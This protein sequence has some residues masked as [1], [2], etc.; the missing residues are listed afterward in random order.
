M[1]FYSTVTGGLLDTAELDAEYWYRNVR[2]MVRFAEAVRRLVAAVTGV[3]GGQST[4]GVD[5]GAAGDAR[6]GYEC[7]RLWVH[8]AGTREERSGCC[9]RWASSMFGAAATGAL[10]PAAR[11]VPLPTYAFERQRYWL[12]AGGAANGDVSSAGLLSA[13]H[14]LLGA[15]IA[16]AEGDN[17]VFTGRLSLSTHAWLG[18]HVVFGAVLL[19]GSAFV[20]LALAAA[21]RVGLDTV[22]ELTLE[23]PLVVPERGALQLQVLVGALDE[24]K[25]RSLSVHARAADNSEGGW[26]RHASG[27]L[28]AAESVTAAELRDW[29]PAGAVA[30]ELDGLYERAAEAGLRYSDAFCG[31]R[32]VYRRGE[33]L[34]A[35]VELPETASLDASRF[36]LHP[37]LLDAALH[38][39]LT[40][41]TPD[42]GIALP[43]IWNGVQLCGRGA[44]AL[45]VRLS[46]GEAQ[47]GGCAAGGR[48]RRACWGGGG[49]A[50]PACGCQPDPGRVGA[51]RCALPGGL[52]D[53]ADLARRLLRN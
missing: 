1:P 22:D 17:F 32:A 16:V 5:H 53:A 44:S 20:E 19:P 2:E 7:A 25:R 33:E 12:D 18:G 10:L 46:G 39:L 23:A 43:F 42:A 45:R 24:N 35:Q 47:G 26:T 40:L 36:G 31:L 48:S 29:P 3:C 15:S 50:Y 38:A 13:E 51:A 49:S 21:Q 14:P 6:G 4:P 37:A 8:C 11:P 30:I 34:F 9:F 41:Q 52:G 27:V 28:S